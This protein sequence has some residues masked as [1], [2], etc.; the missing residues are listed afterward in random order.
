M[1]KKDNAETAIAEAN[2]NSLSSSEDLDQDYP[3]D[4][5]KEDYD[6]GSLYEEMEEDMP[7]FESVDDD[8]PV[9]APDA[10][11]PVL[12]RESLL[13]FSLSNE[14]H[15][16]GVFGHCKTLGA[17]TATS[18]TA[19]PEVAGTSPSQ[20]LIPSSRDGASN[21]ELLPSQGPK[22]CTSDDDAPSNIAARPLMSSDLSF[23]YRLFNM[24]NQAERYKFEDVIS[25][26]QQGTAFLIHSEDRFTNEVLPE[27]FP[28]MKKLKSF[29]RQL[30]AYSF[31]S[32]RAGRIKGA[33]KLLEIDL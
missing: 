27:Y 29:R 22:C 9:A 24:L 32:I 26:V 6:Y 10:S 7:L 11:R 28:N 13:T 1:F 16:E 8:L 14:A 2:T 12:S 15:Q 21:N 18:A 31:T 23:P 19:T 25:W 3:M 33:C 30:S 17:G 4:D 20:A 5:N